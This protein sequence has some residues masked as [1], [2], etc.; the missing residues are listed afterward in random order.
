M[1]R[2]LVT[3]IILISAWLTDS[4]FLELFLE[5]FVICIAGAAKNLKKIWK[6]NNILE[7]HYFNEIQERFNKAIVP[8]DLGKLSTEIESAFDGFKADEWKNFILIFSIYAIK[9]ILPLSHLECYRYFVIACQYICNR[10]INTN[11]LHIADSYL[12]KFYKNLKSCMGQ[13][14]SHP[15]CIST[16]ISRIVLWIWSQFMDFGYFRLNG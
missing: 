9:G 3:S 10:T 11:N 8:S 12:M 5:I 15:T 16:G 4:C 6:E 13:K 2:F 14:K 1:A 7:P